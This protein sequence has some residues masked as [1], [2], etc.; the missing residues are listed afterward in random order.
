VCGSASGNARYATQPSELGVDLDA[1]FKGLEGQFG[2]VR[3]WRGPGWLDPITARSV[4]EAGAT[5]GFWSDCDWWYGSDEKYRP[6]GPG[7][8]PL[9]SRAAARVLR[10]RGYGDSIV[11]PV[12]QAFIEAYMSI[13]PT[14][15]KI[16]A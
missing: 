11:A 4:T 8:Q 10:L 13:Q 7:I 3:D 1:K 15:R 12:A 2:N 16:E 14:E 9:A 6:A 5:R